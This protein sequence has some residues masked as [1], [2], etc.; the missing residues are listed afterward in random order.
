MKL[1]FSSGR[2]KFT[3]AEDL[4]THISADPAQAFCIACHCILMS[5]NSARFV[6]IW[7]NPSPVHHQHLLAACFLVSLFSG[8]PFFGGVPVFGTRNCYYCKERHAKEYNSAISVPSWALYH[9]A[10]RRPC[11]LPPCHRILV[12]EVSQQPIQRP[13]VSM[14]KQFLFFLFFCLYL[15]VV[16]Q[17]LLTAWQWHCHTPASCSPTEP[18]KERRYDQVNCF[19]RTI[20]HPDA[21]I[22][23]IGIV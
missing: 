3:C 12:P 9:Q 14:R 21:V 15:V 4:Q 20:S 1:C 5:M 17:G 13:Q 22:T 16:H 19:I 11:P 2:P 7:D 6:M 18:H 8:I 10:T 23:P